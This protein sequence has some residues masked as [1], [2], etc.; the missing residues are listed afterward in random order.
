M[1]SQN[2]IIVCVKAVILYEGKILI[3]KRAENAHINEGTWEPVGGKLEFG[4]DIESALSREIKEE[5]GLDVS[6]EKI[7]Y[8]T[9][10]KTDPTRQIV[11]LTYLCRSEKNDVVLSEEHEDY[12]W[13]TKDQ[14]KQLLPPN[15]I[16]D[17]EKNNVF[18]LI[19]LH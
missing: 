5:V 15:I 16:N 14:L 11:I 9:T 4:E 8:A 6:I 18:S 19:K 13:S 17:F 3:I 7:L 12:Q 2:K 1:I 10:F